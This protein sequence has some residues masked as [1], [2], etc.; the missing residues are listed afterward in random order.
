MKKNYGLSLK[1]QNEK[2][3]NNEGLPNKHSSIRI[4]TEVLI[5]NKSFL[6]FNL[7]FTYD[8]FHRSDQSLK[9]SLYKL[10]YS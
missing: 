6:F 9:S 7:V 5:M 10:Q 4:V 8:A 2:V 3:G 1:L